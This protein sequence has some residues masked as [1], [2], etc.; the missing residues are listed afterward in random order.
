MKSKALLG[1]LADGQ[2]HSGESLASSLGISRTAI[3][4]QIRRASEEGVRIETIR[5]KG[6]RLLSDMDLLE[7]ERITQGLTPGCRSRVELTVLDEVDSTNAEIVR[8]RTRS[9]SG[10][11]P[12]CIADC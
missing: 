7:A 3:W 9:D 11:I 10:R 2:F 12:V 6:Y 8:R 4:K 5:G 1:L